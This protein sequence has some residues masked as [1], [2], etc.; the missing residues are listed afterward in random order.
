MYKTTHYRTRIS[1]NQSTKSGGWFLICSCPK[2]KKNLR[3][4]NNYTQL[5]EDILFD[6][7]RQTVDV[8]NNQSLIY[9]QVS[10]LQRSRYVP[11]KSRV[12]RNP[13]VGDMKTI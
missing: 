8:Y 13:I 3:N 12:I 2:K 10:L 4:K 11:Q 1:W 9:V 5:V 6:L 7:N